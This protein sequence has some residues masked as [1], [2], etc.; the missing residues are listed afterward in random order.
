MTLGI[1]VKNIIG[2]AMR[3]ENKQSTRIYL[4]T[5]FNQNFIHIRN[6][7]VAVWWSAA[8]PGFGH[9]M[10]NSYIM[11]LVLIIFEFTINTLSN[12]NLGIFYSMIGDFD[13]AKEVI[14][15]RIFFGYMGIY[16]FAMFDCYRRAV[17]LN[18]RCRLGYKKKMNMDE[19]FIVPSLEVNGFEKRSPILSIVWSLIAPGA[20]HIYLQQIP[21]IIFGLTWWGMVAY[22]SHFYDGLYFTLTGDFAIAI[23]KMDP[24][25]FL[26]IPSVY[27]FSTYNAYVEAVEG[28]KLYD[29]SQKQF[30]KEKYQNPNFPM[31]I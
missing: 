1:L 17:S 13:K 2:E 18:E 19:K 9:I 11:G 15:K 28:N 14:N 23:E 20:A 3:N 31:P 6:P 5:S 24:K 30:L 4:T 21:H 26:Y 10:L 22:M 29:Y 25:W 8:F 16:I 7:W 27:M 12:L